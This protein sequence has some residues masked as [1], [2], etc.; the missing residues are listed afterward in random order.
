METISDFMALVHDE[1]GL[2]VTIEDA[3]RNWDEIS[4]W[5]S[6]YMLWLVTIL[7]QKTGRRISVIDVLEA[8]NL[9]YVFNLVSGSDSS[10]ELSGA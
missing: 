10:R 7:E 3:T 4:G 1:L 6:M 5:D 9:K 8:P 2:P